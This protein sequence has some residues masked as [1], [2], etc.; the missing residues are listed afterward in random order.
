M[1]KLLSHVTTNH[2]LP[3]FLGDH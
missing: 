3:K 1:K 2:D